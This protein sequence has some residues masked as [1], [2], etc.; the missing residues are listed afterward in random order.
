[1]KVKA[2]LS[3]L[4]FAIAMA[5]TA[6]AVTV[7]V[8]SD[9][10]IP[11]DKGGDEA[12]QHEDDPLVTWLEDIGYTVDVTGMDQNFREG[13]RS[14][15]AAGNEDK[16][17]ALE[18]ADIV[19]VTRRTSSG[20]YDNDRKEWN[21]LTTS[22]L[23]QSTY[24]I[25][26][27]SNTRW[28]WAT[29]GHAGADDDNYMTWT[30]DGSTTT[31]FDW[32]EST[33][34]DNT[35]P[36]NVRRFSNNVVA[37]GE[38]I[39]T[40]QG[41]N[42]PF[43]V[44]FPEGTDFNA[45]NPD[46]DYGVAGA[47]R[48]FFGHWDYDGTPDG[49]ANGPGGVPSQWDSYIT[50]DYKAVLADL[51]FELSPDPGSNPPPVVDA[52]PDQSAYIGEPAQ[53]AGTVTDRDPMDGSYTGT[54]S[55]YWT[56][57]AEATFTPSDTTNVLDPTVTFSAKG[58]YELMLQASDGDKDA[59]DVVVITVKDR[60]DEFLVGYWPFDGDALDNGDNAEKSDGTLAMQEGGYPKYDS[61][62][63]VGDF[64]I[65]LA[66]PNASDPNMPHVDLGPA[67]ELDFGTTDWTVTAWIKTTQQ[68]GSSGDDGKGAIFG[69]GADSGGGHRYCLIVNEANN[70]RTTLVTDAD[71]NGGKFTTEDDGVD[72]DGDWH[73]IV[74]I[75]D[76]GEI[77]IYRDGVLEGTNTGPPADYDLSG[78]SQ[79][80]SYIGIITKWNGQRPGEADSLYKQFNGLIDDVRVYNYALAVDDPGY[81]SIRSLM[82]MGPIVATV[83]AGPDD[84]FNWKP[85]SRSISL[86]GVV[87]DPGANPE[88]NIVVWTTESVTG[89]ID[90]DAE[91]RFTPEDAAETTATFPEAGVY[92]LKLT[93]LDP[94]APGVDI[95]DT[96]RITVNAPTCDDVTTD[97]RLLVYDFDGDCYIGLSDLKVI[98]ENYLKCNDPL[99]PACPWP[100]IN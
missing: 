15:W 73:F 30:A 46:A 51:L 7:L 81:D 28:G 20:S 44:K 6:N 12:G 13:A 21:E 77:R 82:A 27:G 80:N 11:F 56:G 70:G 69:N 72:N 87:T 94:D 71:N 60:A 90:P 33:D 54:L 66:D 98:L 74:G 50:D 32:S 95:W 99:D 100:F 75:R 31:I 42:R 78:T 47:A 45:G 64:S 61:D 92:V 5:G 41:D 1:M 2:V 39:A 58:V 25:R 85:T 36:E 40:F 38:I 34:G 97:G 18:N 76:G 4:I 49:G 59:N 35:C 37:G 52:G 14:P 8:V 16:L 10:D 65:S 67:T 23:L 86:V 26:G 57:P 3:M 89:T 91:A 9:A 19:I 22:L 96:V 83:D 43:L 62:A 48:T 55:S 17:A 84:E 79:A 29:G 53:L 24:L 88:A 93:V 68:K 63:A